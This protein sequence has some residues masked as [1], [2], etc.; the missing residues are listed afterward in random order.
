MLEVRGRETCVLCAAAECS[1][2]LMVCG[3][4]CALAST[5]NISAPLKQQRKQTYLNT[6]TQIKN[7]QI[8]A[9]DVDARADEALQ[10][11]ADRPARRVTF[12]AAGRL[13]ALKFPDDAGFGRF[14]EDLEVG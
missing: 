13:Y 9:G 1:F 14:M 7:N 5:P 8:D 11:V 4:S 12:G 6:T 3:C 10:Y 2:F